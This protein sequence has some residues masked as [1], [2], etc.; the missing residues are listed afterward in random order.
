MVDIDVSSDRSFGEIH[1]LRSI[2][3]IDE[4]VAIFWF[5]STFWGIPPSLQFA[6][7]SS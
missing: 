2:N 6:C 1:F 7:P 5:R 4:A 3:I